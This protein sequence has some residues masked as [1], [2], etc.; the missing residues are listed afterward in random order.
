MRPFDASARNLLTIDIE[1]P[2]PA[3]PQTPVVGELE[4][5]LGLALRERLRAGDRVLLESEEIVGER[6]LAV[7]EVQRPTTEPATLGQT[8]P[9]AF[10]RSSVCSLAVIVNDVFLMLMKVFS[11]MPIMPG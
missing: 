10:A 9:F 2:G 4:A 6:R 7:V 1:R 3:G 8:V 11:S 5:Q